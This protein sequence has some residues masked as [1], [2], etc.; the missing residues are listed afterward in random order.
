MAISGAIKLNLFYKSIGVRMLLSANEMNQEDEYGG[1]FGEISE[2]FAFGCE[3]A[4]SWD[5]HLTEV[6]NQRRISFSDQKSSKKMSQDDKG[7]KNSQQVSFVYKIEVYTN[8]EDEYVTNFGACLRPSLFII[9]L[10]FL[11]LKAPDGGMIMAM[12]EM[13]KISF[14]KILKI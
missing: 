3:S 2:L 6:S 12:V 4:L 5:S 1:Y 14:K 10:S 7:L 13:V 8:E 9:L 11:Y